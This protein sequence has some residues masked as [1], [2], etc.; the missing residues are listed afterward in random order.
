MS[1]INP[2]IV[3]AGGIDPSDANAVVGD[4]L[5]SKTFYAGNETKKTGTMV[6]RGTVN[7]DITTKAQ[8]VTIAAGKH[9]GSGIVKISA[10]EQAKIIASNIKSGVSILGVSGTYSVSLPTLN[11]PSLSISGSTLTITQSAN[12][13]NFASGFRVYNG[14]TLIATTSG[15]TVDL[16]SYITAVG[17]Y[18]ITAK[19][20]GTNFND[21]AASSSVT[22]TIQPVQLS[23]PALQLSGSALSWGAVSHA[24]YYSLY[25]STSSG[26][27]K[28]ALAD[29]LTGT[30]YDLS[31]FG[32]GTYYITAKAHS[33]SANY[34]DSNYSSE[35][36]YTVAPSEYTIT[37]SGGSDSQ[38]VTVGIA[39]YTQ[40]TATVDAGGSIVVY[41]GGDG[42]EQFTTYTI[43]LNG[44]EV[45]SFYTDS[46]G[47]GVSGEGYDMYT[48]YCIQG[49]VS[50][51][52]NGY[53]AYITT[54]IG[55]ADFATDDWGIVQLEAQ[56]ISKMGTAEDS[57]YSVGDTRTITL[58]T[59]EVITV[60]ILG[61][62]HDTLATAYD[63]GGTLSG[64]SIG[65]YNC[66]AATAGMNSSDTN[67]GGWGSSAM[68]TAMATY[69]SQLPAAV[70]S[71][72][73]PVV[74]KTSAGDKSSTINNSTDSLWLCSH[75]EVMGTHMQTASVQ[76]SFSGEGEQYDY[77][78]L[79]TIPSGCGTAV[80]GTT[81]TYVGNGAT[82]TDRFGTSRTAYSN[83]YLN[84]NNFKGI[85]N[86]PTAAT[87]WWL[88][89]P[90]YGYYQKYVCV[91]NSGSF[92]TDNATGNH[93][94]AF[95]FCI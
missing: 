70:Q 12:N 29:N 22:Y 89:S 19:A 27:T 84:T 35:L 66:L 55:A 15:T 81:G 25:Y 50:V 52:Y 8:E 30:S 20:Y 24:D 77:F 17:S 80:S 49:N 87:T 93:G 38:Y 34:T 26:G 33:S 2:I 53:D 39:S 57:P 54:G 72:I 76:L 31:S 4:V 11:A 90:Y 3:Q 64:I 36:T 63:N 23:S 13:G 65:M 37:V 28:S 9:S 82:Y 69:L 79:A 51:S 43:Y 95:G 32:T 6:D 56:R 41:N 92:S 91:S 16:S 61:F 88:R 46:V 7:T 1:V 59:N 44:S 60:V 48:L 62:N 68:R 10:T 42:S 67:S 47:M 58:S 94:V 73:A 40:G 14:A 74:K 75:K 71:V 5:A 83:Q 45:A 78:K 21:S 18:T 86:S 85:G